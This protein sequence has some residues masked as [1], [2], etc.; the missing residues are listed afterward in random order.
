MSAMHGIMVTV[1]LLAVS[2]AAVFW[3]HNICLLERRAEGGEWVWVNRYP[4]DSYIT[5][6]LLLSLEMVS[7]AQVGLIQMFIDLKNKVLWGK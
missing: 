1:S 7:Y 2:M 5:T 3:A 4:H 6:N